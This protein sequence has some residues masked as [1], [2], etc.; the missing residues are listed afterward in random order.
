MVKGAGTADVL[1]TVVDDI[2]AT[3]P[4]AMVLELPGGHACHLE[5]MDRFLDA[6]ETHLD[7]AWPVARR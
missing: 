4:N 2:A 6:L 1:A 7:H 3:A 5:H